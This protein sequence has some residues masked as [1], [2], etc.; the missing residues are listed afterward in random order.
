VKVVYAV[1]VVAGSPDCPLAWQTG[2]PLG[3]PGSFVLLQSPTSELKTRTE[4]TNL[5]EISLSILRSEFD[6]QKTFDRTDWRLRSSPRST[7]C[8]RSGSGMAPSC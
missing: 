2:R 7:R 5:A 8:E 3:L 4:Q 1:A 6:P